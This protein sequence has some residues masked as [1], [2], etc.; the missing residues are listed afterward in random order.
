MKGKPTMGRQNV[1]IM[2]IQDEKA[3]Q[4]CFSKLRQGLFNKAGELSV[5]C[6]AEVASVVFSPGGKLFSFGHPSLEAI[7]DRFL[8]MGSPNDLA[9]IGGSHGSGE[10]TGSV[11]EMNLQYAKL[12]QLM[13]AE[14]KRKKLLQETMERE[15]GGRV[16]PW[17][18]T[19]VNALGLGEL[20]ELRKELAA[21]QGIVRGKVSEVLSDARRTDRPLP[22]P[23]MDVT[24]ASLFP[25]GG[26]S[27]TPISAT[28]LCSS[29][30]MPEEL[31]V[32]SLLGDVPG[33]GN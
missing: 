15:S 1:E 8:T 13:A 32:N 18:N 30:G 14:K 33:V 6:G 23:R 9:I 19:E 24:S 27:T 3:C 25:S 7:A 20:E 10:V 29:C 4:V 26:Q 16:M 31:D 2:P 11:H 5:L 22:Q 12:K 21:L 28:L 17:L